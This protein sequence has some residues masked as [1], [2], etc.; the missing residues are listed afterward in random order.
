MVSTATFRSTERDREGKGKDIEG[1]GDLCS[2]SLE[3]LCSICYCLQSVVLLFWTWTRQP[4][5]S[6]FVMR[7]QGANV[8]VP[9]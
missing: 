2:G 9:D 8:K 5:R 1:R 6:H 3:E 7:N 4:Y